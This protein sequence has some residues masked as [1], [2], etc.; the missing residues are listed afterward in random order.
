MIDLA[1]LGKE[2]DRS[3]SEEEAPDATLTAFAKEDGPS[4]FAGVSNC[5]GLGR[6][7]CPAQGLP[8]GLDPRPA[9][10]N[11]AP[12]GNLLPFK[13]ALLVLGCRQ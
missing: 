10:I 4:S 11:R 2:S 3:I 9:R 8:P 1:V 13:A 6:T 5:A 7:E 12:N